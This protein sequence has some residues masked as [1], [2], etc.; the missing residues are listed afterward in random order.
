M[1]DYNIIPLGDHCAISMILKDLNI[2]K[3]SYP[4]DW[5]VHTEQIYNTNILYNFTLVKQLMNKVDIR[6]IVNNMIG[7]AFHTSSNKNDNN[8][9]WFPHDTEKC[10]LTI[11]KKYERRFERLFHDIN[12]KKNVFILLTRHY[13]IQETIIEEIMK[14]LLSFNGEN[15][16]LFISGTDHSYLYDEKYKDK[17]IF[18][19][20]SYDITRKFFSY[21]NLFRAQIKDY[22]QSLFATNRDNIQTVM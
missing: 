13:Y 2:R 3:S 17:V 12:N 11:Y 21:D 20:I 18:K 19:Y 8:N 4:F 10:I 14:T 6:Y 16:I 9:L 22:I 15:K 5:I 7:N 1:E